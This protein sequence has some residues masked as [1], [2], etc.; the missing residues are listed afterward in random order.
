M[1]LPSRCLRVYCRKI[2]QNL[3][4]FFRFLGYLFDVK[5]DNIR[6]SPCIAVSCRDVDIKIEGAEN[7]FFH[8]DKI[9]LCVAILTNFDHFRQ[10]RYI[11]LLKNNMIHP[12]KMVLRKIFW[13]FN[14]FYFANFSQQI[15]QSQHFLSNK[16]I[17]FDS[18]EILTP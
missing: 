8:F 7:S 6:E 1:I 2:C 5:I 12:M 17:S 3:E 9:R 14:S 4:E 18:R 16:K 15:N 11:S 13:V 10:S